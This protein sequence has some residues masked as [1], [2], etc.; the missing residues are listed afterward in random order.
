MLV[1]EPYHLIESLYHVSNSGLIDRLCVS[2]VC[3]LLNTGKFF[4]VVQ[5]FALNEIESAEDPNIVFKT[6]CITVR[7]CSAYFKLVSQ[8][9]LEKILSPPI[10]EILK[11]PTKYSL[12]SQKKKALEKNAKNVKLVNYFLFFIFYFFYYLYLYFLFLIIY[13]FYYFLIDDKNPFECYF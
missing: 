9:Y 1:K 6:N 12:K 2:I 7:L 3:T 13:I 4:E 5:Y 8:E 11:D 10:E